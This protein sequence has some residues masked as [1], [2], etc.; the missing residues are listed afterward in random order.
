MSAH[1]PERGSKGPPS[2]RA[3][4]D[5][6]FSG[7]QEKPPIP[8]LRSD[9]PSWQ[10]LPSTLSEA[11]QLEGE[12]NRE[13]RLRALWNRLPTHHKNVEHDENLWSNQTSLNDERARRLWA[14]YEN[15]LRKSCRSKDVS[16]QVAWQD[17][18]EYADKKEA[19]SY[20]FTFFSGPLLMQ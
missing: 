16:S 7:A 2:R 3:I 17:F 18:V 20:L 19:G 9:P 6:S 4:F 10:P 14:M 11:R 5:A 13:A 8:P 12:Q 1:T 15:E